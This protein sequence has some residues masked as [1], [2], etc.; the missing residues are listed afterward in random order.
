M[1]YILCSVRDEKAGVYA[2]PFCAPTVGHAIRSFIDAALR[3]SDDNL[4]FSH[5]ED[6]RLYQV[7][8][9]FDDDGSLSVM[10]PPVLLSS[11]SEARPPAKPV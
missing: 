4:M 2:Q 11:A 10:S 6:F 5:P 3:E 8:E 1:K 9:Y 7:G